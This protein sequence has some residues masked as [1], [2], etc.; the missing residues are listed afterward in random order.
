MN[1]G[2][3]YLAYVSTRTFAMP[4]QPSAQTRAEA[5]T[6][7]RNRGV[8]RLYCRG[9]TLSALRTR[10]YALNATRTMLL[11]A[12]FTQAADK[13]FSRHGMHDECL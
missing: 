8:R 11:S 13:P 6:G 10:C 5:R 12:D 9:Y 7:T 3:A 1:S 2:H 4:L